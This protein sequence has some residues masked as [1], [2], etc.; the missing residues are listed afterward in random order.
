MNKYLK[1]WLIFLIPI[2]L[3]L[4]WR[5]FAN[6]LI[7]DASP[8]ISDPE[9]SET[10]DQIT[11]TQQINTSSPLLWP[12]T[13]TQD[14]LQ[15]DVIL[16]ITVPQRFDPN[17][18]NNTTQQLASQNI[19]IQRITLSGWDYHDQAYRMITSG[20]SDMTLISS[21]RGLDCWSQCGLVFDYGSPIDAFI[22][23]QV[24]NMIRDP[25]WTMIPYSIDPLIL[26]HPTDRTASKSRSA[27]F[28]EILIST[29]TQWNTLPLTI[30]IGAADKALLRA[31]KESYP[32]YTQLLHQLL[33]QFSANENLLSQFITL[34]NATQLWSYSRLA[35]SIDT[36]KQRFPICEYTVAACLVRFK[37]STYGLWYSSDLNLLPRNR[38]S[39]LWY[40]PLPLEISHYPVRLW[41]FIINHN[42]TVQLSVINRFISAYMTEMINQSSDISSS[43]TIQQISPFVTRMDQQTSDPLLAEIIRYT[44]FFHIIREWKQTHY[45]RVRNGWMMPVR[46]RNSSIQYYLSRQ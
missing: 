43:N 20:L 37:V 41:W 26:L 4:M 35:R 18:L 5:G 38:E 25:L 30:G 24:A 21:D 36:I 3:W 44:D 31:G 9:L 34:S 27:L 10:A 1:L 19:T 45:N 6:L 8:T 15:E 39:H 13:T 23:P 42:H 2:V 40:S 16:R 11:G 14:P 17:T 7:G 29:S 46:E 12:T 22:I 32:W 33:V 28:N